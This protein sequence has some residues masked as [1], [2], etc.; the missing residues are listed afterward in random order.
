MN[1][2]L[3]NMLLT[4][5]MGTFLSSAAMARSS[6]A[7]NDNTRAGTTESGSYDNGT[8]DDS[9]GNVNTSRDGDSSSSTSYKTTTQNKHKTDKYGNHTVKRTKTETY[10]NK[11]DGSDSQSDGR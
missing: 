3:K 7:V 11:S 10:E 4:V 8:N 5:T 2:A 1:K 6:S 9:A